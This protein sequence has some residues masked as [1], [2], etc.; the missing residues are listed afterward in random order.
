MIITNNPDVQSAQLGET[1]L[2]RGTPLDVLQA[3]SDY[4]EKGW[5]LVTHPLSANNRLNKSPYRSVVLSEKNSW[6]GSERDILDRA[7]SH[8]SLQGFD[9]PGDAD[10][11][12]RWIDLEHL[13]TALFEAA[14]F[15]L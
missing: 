15:H 6:E 5:H 12:Y 7:I 3:V 9:D 10:A 4:M 13:K 14:K 1:L 8:L 11:D 2:V